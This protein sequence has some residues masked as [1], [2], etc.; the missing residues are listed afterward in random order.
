ML[1]QGR[2]ERKVAKD[3]VEGVVTEGEERQG[4]GRAA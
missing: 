2:F 1:F 4:G 3:D